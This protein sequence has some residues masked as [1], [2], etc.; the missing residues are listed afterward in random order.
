GAGP[1]R[2]GRVPA[3][4]AGGGPD[5]HRRARQPRP[6]SPG[7]PGLLRRVPAAPA[8]SGGRGDPVRLRR[9]P[10]VGEHGGLGS[11][12]TVRGGHWSLACG[13]WGAAAREPCRCG[14][15]ACGGGWSLFFW[16]V[17]CPN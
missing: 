7:G 2:L 4:V 12:A 3:A 10:T 6:A 15:R 5:R 8:D 16:T 1:S 11:T 17:A 13:E 9:V 14:A